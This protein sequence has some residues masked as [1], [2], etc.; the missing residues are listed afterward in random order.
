MIS[1]VSPPPVCRLAGFDCIRQLTNL[2]ENETSQTN[3]TAAATPKNAAPSTGGYCMFTSL[4]H[5]IIIS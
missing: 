4:P 5:F 3:L 2:A 1:C